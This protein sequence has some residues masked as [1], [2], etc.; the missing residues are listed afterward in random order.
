MHL[1]ALPIFCQKKKKKKPTKH[2]HTHTRAHTHTHMHT[3]IHTHT[4]TIKKTT[5]MIS[6]LLPMHKAFSEKDSTLKGKVCLPLA[7]NSFLLGYFKK[8]GK[9]DKTE[10]NTLKVYTFPLNDFVVFSLAMLAKSLR[11]H[12]YSNI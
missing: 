10:L 6:R 4:H 2:T 11:K 12:A 8:E 9:Y 1:V 5:F 3:H 7:A